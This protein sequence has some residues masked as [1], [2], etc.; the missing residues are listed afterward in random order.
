MPNTFEQTIKMEELIKTYDLHGL[1]TR[2]GKVY[3]TFKTFYANAEKELA[4][5]L[6]FRD[7]TIGQLYHLVLLF[8]CDLTDFDLHPLW[9]KFNA[10]ACR[11][12]TLKSAVLYHG[13][14]I[15]LGA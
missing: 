7:L 13:K 2:T 14:K 3:N 9:T 8:I 1:S 12:V 10:A 4:I 6:L 5:T 11:P 15:G